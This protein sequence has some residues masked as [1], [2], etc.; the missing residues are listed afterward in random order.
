MDHSKHVRLREDELTQ[1]VLERAVYT[2][3]S[4]HR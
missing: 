4:R 1:D 3:A 2:K